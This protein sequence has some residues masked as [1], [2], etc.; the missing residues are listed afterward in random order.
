MS[1][2]RLVAA[3]IIFQALGV[4]ASSASCGIMIL[5]QSEDWLSVS[6]TGSE[7]AKKIGPKSGVPVELRLPNCQGNMYMHVITSKGVDYTILS[8]NR[9]GTPPLHVIDG[10]D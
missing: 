10:L 5:N 2:G 8:R 1:I 9:G 4:S 6:M 7:G 3:T